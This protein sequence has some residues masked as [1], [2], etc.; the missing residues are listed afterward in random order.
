MLR[1]M[2]PLVFKTA[3]TAT[4]R[5]ILFQKVLKTPEVEDQVLVLLQLQGK[6]KEASR[7]FKAFT[8]CLERILFHEEGD[9]YLRFEAALKQLNGILQ[10]TAIMGMLKKVSGLVALALEDGTIHISHTG[11]ASGYLVRKGTMLEITEYDGDAAA[12]GFLSISSGDLMKNDV[13][14]FTTERLLRSL[15]P[16]QIAGLAL[17]PTRLL[18][19]ICNALEQEKEE[20]T[21][22]VL[23]V[24]PPPAKRPSLTG[25]PLLR[26]RHGL[27]LLLPFR[28]LHALLTALQQLQ[29]GFSRASGSFRNL[30]QS[31]LKRVTA[32]LQHPKKRRRTHLLI[33]TS[34]IAVFLILW[35]GLQ[36]VTTT[37]Q[38]RTRQE[39]ERL[40]TNIT[41][42]LRTATN[43]HLM[44]DIES[45]NA[46]L[47]R[48]E[49]KARAV[50]GSE[51]GLFR[52][53]ALQLLEQI[54][55]KREEIGAVIR[56]TPP[57]VVNIASVSAEVSARGAIVA[58]N[59][60]FILNDRQRLYS[61][62]PT[63]ITGP[64]TVTETDFIEISSSFKR[65][66][67]AVFLLRGGG[68]VELTEG[69]LVPMKTN[70]PG[71]WIPGKSAE[72][73]LR[74]LY[75]LS[76]VNNQIYKYERL[77]G[78]YSA[79]SE[80]NINGDLLDA[81]D[82]AIDGDVYVLKKGGVIQKLLRGEVQP[83]SFRNLPKEALSAAT[84]ILKPSDSGDF[85]FLDPENSRIIITGND[86][87]S[88]E[89]VYRKQYVLTGEDTGKLQDIA[90]DEAET[91]LYVLDEKRVYAIDLQKE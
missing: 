33:L 90:I 15:T 86:R 83:F 42:S 8:E 25:R 20:A 78:L 48:A 11:N 36:L 87:E 82:L 53:E 18:D 38:G 5:S 32:D 31:T 85:Y 3:K 47:E 50:M 19:E 54:K 61:A 79:P 46:I 72:T 56:L 68:V 84:R 35:V 2:P 13:L 1:L 77:S 67:T 28:A 89:S 16:A 7:V 22:A 52:K 74:Y 88:G 12:S 73:Y 66:G 39:L 62:T 27:S 4:A 51:S 37:Q 34:V 81:M 9:P 40:V 76:P 44:G 24:P 26:Q 91:T 6:E 71:G 10:G 17:H 21:L 69:S 41:E 80:Y 58:P 43:R 70:D 14:I 75:V 49:Q 60:E 64:L 29:S 30:A 63:S 55:Q 23:H 65:Y 57:I 45:A 59:G